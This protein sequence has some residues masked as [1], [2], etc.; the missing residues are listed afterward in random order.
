VKLVALTVA[1]ATLT[2]GGEAQTI[3]PA[4][5]TFAALPNTITQD[6]QSRGCKLPSIRS[7]SLINGEFLRPGQ[8]DWAVLC[9]TKKSTS[10]L[11]Y[12][13][14][15]QEQVTVLQT[16]PRGF[17]KWS[18]GVISQE[19]LNEFKTARTW[20]GPAPPEI[21]HQGIDSFVEFGRSGE[22]L[23]CYSAEGSIHYH[24]EDKWLVPLI[25]AVN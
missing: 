6:L 1:V 10:L 18:I 23:Y 3:Q 5:F 12:P 17:S 8:S 19:R 13:G 15:S 25:M 24:H 2:L 16:V 14:G 11:V 20:R 21:D 22:C 7:K 4:P 9:S